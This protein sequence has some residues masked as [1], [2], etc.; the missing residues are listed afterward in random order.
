MFPIRKRRH[1]TKSTLPAKVPKLTINMPAIRR[2]TNYRKKST[3][4]KTYTGPN[5]TFF[6]PNANITAYKTAKWLYQIVS[7]SL[8]QST[9]SAVQVNAVRTALAALT[10]FSPISMKIHN[11]KAYNMWGSAATADNPQLTMKVESLEP[12][13]GVLGKIDDKGLVSDPARVGYKWPM[14]SSQ[15]LFH[16]T[17]N[18]TIAN[19]T[20][21]TGDNAICQ[22][23][24]SYLA[25]TS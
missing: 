3:Y 5:G 24:V 15:R 19:I 23:G 4:K 1:T 9:D 21:S 13:G 17:A 25:N 20:P 6:K 14:L 22:V 11:I 7:I 16:L 12:S 2:K 18:Q 10:G 8:T